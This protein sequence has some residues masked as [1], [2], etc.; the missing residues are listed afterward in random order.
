MDNAYVTG[1]DEKMEKI[2]PHLIRILKDWELWESCHTLKKTRQPERDRVTVL[3]Q[4]VDE[5]S[6]AAAPRILSWIWLNVIVAYS[7]TTSG[8]L[9][10]LPLVQPPLQIR[11]ILSRSILKWKWNVLSSL[12]YIVKVVRERVALTVDRG[13]KAILADLEDPVILE[14]VD[15]LDYEEIRVDRG[16]LAPTANQEGLDRQDL[17]VKEVYNAGR[18][19]ETLLHYSA[20]LYQCTYKCT[21]Y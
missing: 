13:W 7:T 10:N 6:L 14:H 16:V 20:V 21:Y 1:V 17:P 2:A 5:V 11:P 18:V 9:F 19:A 8:F 4:W 3:H 15:S 12:S